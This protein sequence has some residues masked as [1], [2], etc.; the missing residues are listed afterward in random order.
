MPWHFRQAKI[1]LLVGKR[2]WGGLWDSSAGEDLM[3]GGVVTLRA[4]FLDSQQQMGVENNGIA[5]D[6]EVEL[7]P[8][9]VR[10]GHDPNSRRPSSYCFPISRKIPFPLTRSRPI[11]NTSAVPRRPQR[12]RILE[13]VA[14][15]AVSQLRSRKKKVE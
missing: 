1:G 2:T 10:E 11:P 12:I 7:D 4:R 3:D 6:V 14:S 9:A 13:A 8:Q 5:P 15:E